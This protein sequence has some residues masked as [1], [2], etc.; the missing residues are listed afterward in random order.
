MAE[1]EE[2][3]TTD[4]AGSC[5]NSARQPWLQVVLVES[6]TFLAPE[7]FFLQVTPFPAPSLCPTSLHTHPS[8][9]AAASRGPAD[10]CR[11]PFFCCFLP[12]FGQRCIFSHRFALMQEYQVA[13]FPSLPRNPRAQQKQNQ[14]PG[15]SRSSFMS[16]QGL[17]VMLGEV[18]QRPTP[19]QEQGKGLKEGIRTRY[20]DPM[21]SLP[22]G[23]NLVALTDPS[24]HLPRAAPVAAEPPTE[25]PCVSVQ[26]QKLAAADPGFQPLTAH[27]PPWG[28]GGTP[29]PC[30]KQ[31]GP[32]QASH[33]HMQKQGFPSCAL[34]LLLSPSSSADG[35]SL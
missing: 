15:L 26:R 20:P 23:K 29:K 32:F 3:G 7:L 6:L 5:W 27:R 4:L 28:A 11:F 9:S 21:T 35:K 30:R 22:P 18:G 24:Q 10:N 25:L 16:R 34:H 2:P 8:P 13:A 1:E 19:R 14:V 17:D 31:E 12:R 33:L